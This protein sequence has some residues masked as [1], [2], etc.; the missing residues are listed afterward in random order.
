MSELDE[1]FILA[2]YK[3]V[4][5]WDEA[6]TKRNVLTPVKVAWAG[7]GAA[8]G[9][10][11]D[12]ESIMIYEFPAACFKVCA[13]MFSMCLYF[14]VFV[15]STLVQNKDRPAIP[16]PKKLSALDLKWISQAYPVPEGAFNFAALRSFVL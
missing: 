15:V 16:Q 3:E 10:A 14:L 8:T 13:F 6:I 9:K 11:P 7:R 5:E 12:L 4:F 2:Y 1:D